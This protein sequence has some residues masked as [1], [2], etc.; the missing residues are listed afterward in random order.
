MDKCD[1]MLH[2]SMQC[3]QQT[4]LSQKMC[5]EKYENCSSDCFPSCDVKGKYLEI[6]NVSQQ[7]GVELSL[8]DMQIIDKNHFFRDNK[9]TLL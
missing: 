7:V 2:N 6:H 8:I 1:D 9:N 3:L 4:I 5:K